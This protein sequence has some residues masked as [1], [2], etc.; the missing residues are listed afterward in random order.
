MTSVYVGNY[1]EI[2]SGITRT[3]Y[4][5]GSVRV[6]EKSSGTLYFLLTDHPSTALCEASPWDRG[7]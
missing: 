7:G 4:Y 6:A 2:T 3:Y 5:A 1:F